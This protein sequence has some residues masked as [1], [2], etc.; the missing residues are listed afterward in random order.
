MFEDGHALPNFGQT[1]LEPAY[2]AQYDDSVV[3]RI[4]RAIKY[5]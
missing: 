1:L 4:R 3:D 2:D 5:L